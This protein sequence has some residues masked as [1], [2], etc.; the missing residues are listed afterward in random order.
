[1]L[2]IA[3]CIKQIPLVEEANFDAATRTIRRDGPNVISAFDLRAISLAV[4]LKNRH[5]AETTVVTMGPPQ[6]R[7]ALV[8]ALATGMDR[9]AHLED[10]AFAGA[11]TLATARA[12]ALWLT[13][14]NFDLIL[15][16][17]YSLDAETGQ[18]GPEI[19]ELIG[20]A[21]ITGA[22][23]L[24]IDGRTIRAERESDEG[25]EEIEAAMPAVITCAERIATPVKLKPGAAEE[26]KTRP[27]ES[28]RAAEL[29]ADPKEFGLAGSPTWV[30][31]VRAVAT[32]KTECKFIDSTGAERAAAEV[33]SA[34]ETIG[35]LNPRAHVRRSIGSARRASSRSRD[36]WIVCE[37]DLEGRVT[38]GTLEMLSRGDELA[39]RLGGALVAVGFGGAI[40]RHAG[41]LASFGADQVLIVEHPALASY[42]PEAAA[43]AVAKLTLT[44]APWGILIGATERGRDWGPRLAARLSLGLTGD[45]IDIELDS[46]RRMVAL[47]PAFGG[48]IVASIYSK[49]FPQMATVRPGVLE[50]A[51]PSQA[52]DAEI[53]IE[54]PELSAPKSRLIKAHSILDATIAPLESS[55]VVVGIGMG[56]GG[57]D[58]VAKAAAFARVLG[59]AI[60]A[61]RRVTD[62]GWVPRQLQVG[63]TG[64]SI[65]PRLYIAIGVRGASN[66]TC[67]LKRADTIV[68]I[69]NDADAPIF[70]RANI[71]LVADWETVL[72]ALQDAFRRR[73]Q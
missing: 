36:L 50:L 12:L 17:K 34:L 13:R 14:G 9:A 39:S 48:N 65:D 27:I 28:V 10:R 62:N 6:A 58:G 3:V 46:E 22:R 66:H 52:R 64:K 11:D 57:P 30:D 2:K 24:E 45:A 23:K 56:I 71:G 47:K 31:E 35:A 5:G 44:H 51:A 61:T 29:G 21:Q 33:I 1:M 68:A 19:A 16:G 70:E 32:P 37:T 18:V 20:A 54:R 42:T 59:A 40:A 7:D 49:T 53:R 73:L 38:R 41:C 55:E 43:E 72:P 60:C 4:E 67:G 8:D 25:F 26:A 63:L 69:N 15:L